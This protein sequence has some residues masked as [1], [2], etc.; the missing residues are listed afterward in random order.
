MEL[1][2]EYVKKA[3]KIM[4]EKSIR[5]GNLDDFRRRYG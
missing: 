1:K 5:I 2:P 3:K 4:K